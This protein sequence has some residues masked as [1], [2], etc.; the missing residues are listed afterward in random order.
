MA[1][2]RKLEN[3][4]ITQKTHVWVLNMHSCATFSEKDNEHLIKKKLIEQSIL[5]LIY[6]LCMLKKYNI[7]Y[8]LYIR[9]LCYSI[10]FYFSQQTKIL[11]LKIHDK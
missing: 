9:I 1:N 4:I 5:N 6:T 11:L 8:S 10:S 2:F 3:W 7:L